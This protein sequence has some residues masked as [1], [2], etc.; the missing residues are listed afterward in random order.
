MPEGKN[1]AALLEEAYFGEPGRSGTA[2]HGDSVNTIMQ[3]I[4]AS[5]AA[6]RL[7]GASHSIWEILLHITQWDEICVRRLKGEVFKM[8]TGDPED[9]PNLPENLDANNWQ[10]ALVRFRQAQQAMIDAARDMSEN[11]LADRV[12]GTYWNNPLGRLGKYLLEESLVGRGLPQG[13][14]TIKVRR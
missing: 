4:D 11:D 13:S 1:L 5:L 8:T 6:R 7:P 14:I 9:W 2:W 3:G 12:P 10:K